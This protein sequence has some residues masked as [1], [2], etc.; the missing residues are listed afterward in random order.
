M[1]NNWEEKFDNYF[2]EKIGKDDGYTEE[3][4]IAKDFIESLLAEQKKELMEELL[5]KL[6]PKMQPYW[7]PSAEAVQYYNDCRQE[8]VDI[9]ESLKTHD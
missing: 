5:S 9:I 4:R 3:R 7:C 2:L 1:K 6:P 8:V